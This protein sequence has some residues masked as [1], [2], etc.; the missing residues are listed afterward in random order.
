MRYYDRNGYK[1]KENEYKEGK[2]INVSTMHLIMPNYMRKVI[3]NVIFVATMNDDMGFQQLNSRPTV[4]DSVDHKILADSGSIPDYPKYKFG[5]I[6][7][8]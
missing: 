6:Y 8:N 1:Q 4:C 5:M 3:K 7:I 2:G